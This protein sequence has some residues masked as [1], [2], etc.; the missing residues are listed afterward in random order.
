MWIMSI[1]SSPESSAHPSA[2]NRL[3]DHLRLFEMTTQH[4][5]APPVSRHEPDMRQVSATRELFWQNVVQEM[6]TGLASL[7]QSGTNADVFDGRIAVIT[8]LGHRIPVA[9]VM[10]LFAC[11]VPGSDREKHLSMAVECTVF[12]I[13]TP[14]GEVFTLPLHE[15]R[16]IHALSEELAERVKAAGRRENDEA[17]ASDQPFGFAAFTSLARQRNTLPEGTIVGPGLP[18]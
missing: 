2:G 1:F 13:R 12:Q 8:S 3:Y 10:P 9:D 5:K 16:M 14:D 18:L 11:G 4:R 17:N 15:A 6:L 7:S